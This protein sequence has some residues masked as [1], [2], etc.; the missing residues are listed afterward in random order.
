MVN[1]LEEKK[2]ENIL[3]LDIHELANF[4]DY[5]VL[6]SGTSERMLEALADAVC[7]SAKQHFSLIPRQEGYASAGWVVVDL[8]DVVVH[9]F[10]PER[11][12]YYRLEDLWSQAKVLVRLQ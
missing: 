5:F 6:C 7:E 8:G 10:S 9:L 11:R 2:G 4:A 3:L 12:N 1:A